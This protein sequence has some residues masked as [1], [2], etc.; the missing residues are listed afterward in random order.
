[1]NKYGFSHGTSILISNYHIKNYN[2]LYKERMTKKEKK[3]LL[4]PIRTCKTKSLLKTL[5]NIL[6]KFVKITLTSIINVK[7][8]NCTIVNLS[9]ISHSVV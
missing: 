8:L 2:I 5:E 9:R 6:N 7:S 3:S 1:M 4:K